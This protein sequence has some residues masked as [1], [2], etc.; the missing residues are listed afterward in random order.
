MADDARSIEADGEEIDLVDLADIPEDERDDDL[1]LAI[2]EG[3]A[4][5]VAG[6]LVPHAQVMEW[7]DRV[8]TPGE[9]PMPREWLPA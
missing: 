9:T 2:A 7:L 8:G 4:D 5:A 3:E 1:R 6:R